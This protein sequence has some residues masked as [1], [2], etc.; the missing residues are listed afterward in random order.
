M[1]NFN[2]KLKNVAL[3]TM[4][5]RMCTNPSKQEFDILYKELVETDDAMR[6]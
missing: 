5:H 6:A 3:K 2:T 1:S 4:L